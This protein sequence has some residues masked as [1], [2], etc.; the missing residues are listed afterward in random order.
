MEA[1][2][3]PLSRSVMP[4]ILKHLMPATQ[5]QTRQL[6]ARTEHT[7]SWAQGSSQMLAEIPQY[8]QLPMTCPKISGQAVKGAH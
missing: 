4:A 3:K 8:P 1:R 2:K 7:Q 5:L 6:H